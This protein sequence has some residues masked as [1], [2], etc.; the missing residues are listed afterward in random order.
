MAKRTR[1]HIIVRFAYHNSTEEGQLETTVNS[2][3]AIAIQL[4]ANH[5]WLTKKGHKAIE[6][7]VTEV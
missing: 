7:I 3:K 1:Y 6:E 2:K 4:K 5:E